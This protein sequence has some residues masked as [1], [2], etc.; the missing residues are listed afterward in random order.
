M[1]QCQPVLN[2]TSALFPCLAPTHSA[3]PTCPAVTP[4]CTIPCHLYLTPACYPFRNQ[5]SSNYASPSLHFPP[6]CLVHISRCITTFHSSLFFCLPVL[7]CYKPQSA[8]LDFCP[9]T[10]CPIW[11]CSPVTDFHPHAVLSKLY[12]SYICSVCESCFWVCCR[13]FVLRGS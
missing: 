4:V 10:L 9:Y 1:S 11:M 5:Q 6:D 2:P 13:H 7:A 12:L 3:T 8:F